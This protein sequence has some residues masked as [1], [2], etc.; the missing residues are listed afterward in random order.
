MMPP[1][2]AYY[3]AQPS[4]Y[5]SNQDL[6]RPQKQRAQDGKKARE[7]VMSFDSFFDEAGHYNEAIDDEREDGIEDKYLSQESQASE[8]KGE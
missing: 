7:G 8:A 3:G 5:A 6:Q 1:P 4:P 2:Q